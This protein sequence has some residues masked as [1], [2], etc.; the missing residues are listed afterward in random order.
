M[1]NKKVKQK[2][3]EEEEKQKKWREGNKKREKRKRETKKEM[4]GEKKGE[5]EKEKQKKEEGAENNWRAFQHPPSVRAA[6]WRTAKCA[7][8]S[9]SSVTLNVPFFQTAGWETSI[10]DAQSLATHPCMS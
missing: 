2:N 8:C 1:R 4:M 5:R 9:V 3:G 6:A 7:Y 10:S